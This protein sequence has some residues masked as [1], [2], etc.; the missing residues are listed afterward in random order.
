MSYYEFVWF[1]MSEED[2]RSPTRYNIIDL[3]HKN[4]F[5]LFL[6]LNIGFVVWI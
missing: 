3:N 4:S 2:K 6:V 5:F 1:L